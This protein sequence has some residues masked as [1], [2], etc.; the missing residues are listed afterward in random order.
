MHSP[1]EGDLAQDD[2]W[3]HLEQI[4]RRYPQGVAR[5]AL[6]LET[7]RLAV[8]W[9]EEAHAAHSADVTGADPAAARPAHD[10]GA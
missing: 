8:A 1:A 9:V 5:L 10:S 6:D 7:G 3:K 4:R 2:F